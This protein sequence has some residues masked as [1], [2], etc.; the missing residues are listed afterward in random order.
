MAFRT[1]QQQSRTQEPEQESGKPVQ[2]FRAGALS[3]SVWAREH[4][5][6]TFYTANAQRAYTEDDGKSW[7]YSGSFDR[8]DL[9]TVAAL[10]N[11]AL[12]WIVKES[13]Q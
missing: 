10:L 4:E 12:A 2:T 1:T 6:K 3:V 5:G 9:A 8:D 11:M 13:R 7:K